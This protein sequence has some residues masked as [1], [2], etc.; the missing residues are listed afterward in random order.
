MAASRKRQRSSAAPGGLEARVRA[1]LGA[2]VA[3]GSRVRLGL[4]GGVDSIVLLDVLTRLAPRAGYT[5]EVLHVDH[6][7]NPQSRA[8][9]RFCRAACE[10]RDVLCRVV[11]VTVPR[12]NSIERA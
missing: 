11:R 9:A 6:G 1:H 7:L 3:R 12:S 10:A 4:S 2:H 5:L 8:W